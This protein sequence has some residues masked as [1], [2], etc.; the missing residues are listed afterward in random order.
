MNI[1]LLAC[2]FWECFYW[3]LGRQVWNKVIQGVLVAVKYV[4][5]YGVQ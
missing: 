3:L 1:T 2:V 5:V 4:F